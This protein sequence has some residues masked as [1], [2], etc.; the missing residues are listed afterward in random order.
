MPVSVDASR[1]NL[2]GLKIRGPKGVRVRV[3]L[4][5]PASI[6]ES[7]D[8]PRTRCAVCRMTV[9]LRASVRV[10]AVRCASDQTR[11]ASA[12]PSFIVDSVIRHSVCWNF[13]SLNGGPQCVTHQSSP[14]S[15]FPR[16]F[17]LSRSCT[18]SKAH[19]PRRADKALTGLHHLPSLVLRSRR[20]SCEAHQLQWEA[21][22]S[23]S[24]SPGW[25][26]SIPECMARILANA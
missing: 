5:A 8:G 15:R 11:N 20:L 22:H 1:Y 17:R 3:P 12:E 24:M 10:A 13:G 23:V 7:P 2:G 18:R 25:R 19:R 4:R 21:D 16:E 9:G 26:Q 6:R 14:R